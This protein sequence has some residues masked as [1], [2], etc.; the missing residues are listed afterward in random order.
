MYNDR[1]ASLLAQRYRI[2]LP[3]QETQVWSLG[4][5]DPLEKEMATRSS[6]LGWETP[7][8]PGGLQS[9]GWQRVRHSLVTKTTIMIITPQQVATDRRDVYPLGLKT[10]LET[11]SDEP[12]FGDWPISRFTGYRM[13]ELGGV[14]FTS[15]TESKCA[16]RPG[17]L[18]SV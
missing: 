4:W 12:P 13:W 3:M 14:E 16:S 7:E 5:I 17:V 15:C 1:R 2:C 10:C 6:I 11:A 18:H 9:M 8:E